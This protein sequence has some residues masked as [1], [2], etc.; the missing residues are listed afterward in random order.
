MKRLYPFLDENAIQAKRG[1]FQRKQCNFLFKS[2][3]FGLSLLFFNIIKKHAMIFSSIWL[4][5]EKVEV[6]Y[7]SPAYAPVNSIFFHSDQSTTYDPNSTDYSQYGYDQ[8]YYASSGATGYDYSQYGP[9]GT[10]GYDAAHPYDSSQYNAQAYGSDYYQGYDYGATGSEAYGQTTAE[11]GYDTSAYGQTSGT[12]EEYDT[13]VYGQ[14]AG[15]EG[16]DTSQ[17]GQAYS[18]TQYGLDAYGAQGDQPTD[19]YVTATTD[20][21]EYDPSTGAYKEEHSNYSYTNHYESQG[22]GY[23]TS[24]YGQE[25]EKAEVKQKTSKKLAFCYFFKL[26]LP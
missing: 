22:Y 11:G 14:T 19:Q 13:S 12:G 25:V 2:A 1:Y 21:Y 8:N 16:Y 24:G 26:L 4:V 20:K 3:I 15:T 9:T 6:L 23:D 18:A 5:W 7:S 17:Y 10:E